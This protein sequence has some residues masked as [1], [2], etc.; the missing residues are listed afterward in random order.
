MCGLGDENEEKPKIRTNFQAVSGRTGQIPSSSQKATSSDIFKA[1]KKKHQNSI[2]YFAIWWPRH[3]IHRRTCW[4]PMWRSA[5]AHVR[6]IDPARTT[7]A[8]EH[9]PVAGG[10]AETCPVR[11]LTPGEKHNNVHDRMKMCKLLHV[12]IC[13]RANVEKK[14]IDLTHQ[15]MLLGW[16]PLLLL[17]GERLVGVVPKQ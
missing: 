17:R 10:A 11:V 16:R 13:A 3:A 14:N 7:R 9:A 8:R 4:P 5:D 6:A 12:S 1:D 15:H 2:A